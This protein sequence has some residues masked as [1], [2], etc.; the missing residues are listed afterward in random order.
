MKRIQL[1][2]FAVALIL[3]SSCGNKFHY[4]EGYIF[5]TTYHVVYQS[6]T[7]LKVDYHARLQDVD[8]SLSS[9]NKNSIIT[10]VNNNIDVE[11]DSMFIEV[12]N[13]SQEI[14]Q[15][16]DGAFDITVA[17]L[18]NAWGFGFK[19]YKENTNIDSLMTFVG[20]NKIRLDGKRIIKDIPEIQLITSAI[21]KGYGV[22]VVADYLESKGINNYMVEIGGEIRAS[23]LNE[24]KSV[25]RVGI[26]KPIDDVS[27]SNRVLQGV[28]EMSKGALATSG[29]YRNFYIKDGKKYSH[30]IDPRTGYPVQHSVLSA[31]VK[32][33]NCMVADAYATSFMVL[34]IEK[35]EEIVEKD[36][37]LEAYIIY[38]EDG[39]FKVWKSKGFRTV[40]K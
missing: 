24:K 34:G 26:D 19:K 18:V 14:S 21:A 25:W 20:Y 11:C 23:G 12:F 15:K 28:L 8:N 37:S 33:P 2:F 39:K 31:S 36:S 10:K 9:F 4:D 5:G 27:A 40:E 16:T 32:A 17:P 3:L 13:T 6:D 29:N 38:S 1:I 35:A 22:D 7:N 30:T